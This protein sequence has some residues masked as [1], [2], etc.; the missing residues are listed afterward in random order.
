MFASKIYVLNATPQGTIY[1]SEE[2]LQKALIEDG[3]T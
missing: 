3:A 1:L 2:D